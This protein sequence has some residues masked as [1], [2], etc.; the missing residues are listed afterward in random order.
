[1]PK[2]G[3]FVVLAIFMGAGPARGGLYSAEE[4][5]TLFVGMPATGVKDMKPRLFQR[6]YLTELRRLGRNDPSYPLRVKFQDKVKDLLRRPQPLSET[7]QINLSFYYIRLGQVAEALKLLR[8][9]DARGSRHFMVLGNLATA[10]QLT[11]SAGD[12]PRLNLGRAKY[13]LDRTLRA[14]PKEWVGWSP[15]R[16]AW[17]RK[18]EE[19]Q[20]RLI[21]LRLAEIGKAPRIPRVTD[22]DALFPVSFHGAAKDGGY[23][24]GKPPAGEENK[25]KGDEV[26]LVMQLL[27]WLPDD[28]RLYWLLG[29]LL[30]ASGDVPLAAI[31]LEDCVY[32]QNMAAPLLKEHRSILKQ[33]AAARQRPPIT[34]P[35]PPPESPPADAGWLPDFWQIVVVGGIGGLIV[36][37]LAYF[38]VRELRRRRRKKTADSVPRP[39]S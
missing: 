8:D 13:Y 21:K 12:N 22:V 38:Q 16:L 29:E 35:M 14:W 19:T 1:M 28:N 33:A 6:D 31:I 27:T 37:I 25:L 34:P 11:G 2:L 20:L 17:Y 32:N 9:L 10:Y 23:R 18:A 7:D 39:G 26:P 24:A 36:L 4:P 30:N 5:P 3:A 15:Q